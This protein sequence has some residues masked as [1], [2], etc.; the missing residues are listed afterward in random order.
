VPSGFKAE[1]GKTSACRREHAQCFFSSAAAAVGLCCGVRLTRP[2]AHLGDARGSH[3][4][5][6]QRRAH[7]G[8]EGTPE[9]IQL[10]LCV[11]ARAR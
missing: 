5:D 1:G 2:C 3:R 10:R 6:G 8:A 4:L 11:Q 9:L 7:P